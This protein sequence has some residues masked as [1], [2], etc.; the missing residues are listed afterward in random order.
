MD[1]T[2]I[3]VG[4][5]GSWAGAGALLW[6]IQAI[7]AGVRALNVIAAELTAIR[8]ALGVPGPRPGPVAPFVVHLQRPEV[9]AA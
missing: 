9:P 3:T 8:E 2:L 6:G 4:D 1:P 5:L 7:G